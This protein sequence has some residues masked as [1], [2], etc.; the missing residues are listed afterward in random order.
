MLEGRG[1]DISVARQA[2]YLADWMREARLERAILVGHD[3]GGG[4]AQLLAVKQPEL[5]AG[6]VLTNSICYDS[7]PIPS[8][9]MMQRSGAVVEHLPKVVFR[10]IIRT[11]LARGH[12]TVTQANEAFPV[13][14]PF[15]EAADGAVAFIRQVR[16]LNVDDTLSV[17][18]QLPDLRIRARVVWGEADQF[19][20]IYYGARLANDLNA[21]LDVIKGAKHLCQRTTR[22]GSRTP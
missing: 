7:W 20:K 21:P 5:V 3:L 16:S 6:L 12:E 15:Y 8:V 19:Q 13:H 22:T 14:W 11:F 1:R 2:D 10:Q 4:V 17:A 9:K 18:G